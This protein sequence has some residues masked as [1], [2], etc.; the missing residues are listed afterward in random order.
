MLNSICIAVLQFFS[1]I[2]KNTVIK[3]KEKTKKK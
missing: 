2:K 3:N 1:L